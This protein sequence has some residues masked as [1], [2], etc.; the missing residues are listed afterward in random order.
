[1]ETIMTPHTKGKKYHDTILRKKF[2]IGLHQ[3]QTLLEEQDG[4]CYL[5]GNDSWRNL[6][7]D[8]CHTTGKVRR[9]LCSPCNQALGLFYDN[10][11][12]MRKAADYVEA[13]FTLP[14]DKEVI[15]KP[16]SERAR[17]RNVVTTPKGVYNSFAEAG[18]VYGVDATTIGSWCG[19]YKNSFPKE[20]FTYEKVFK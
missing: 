13:E 5:C 4:K 12:V 3:Y 1:M 17:H 6:A 14:E 19:A 2:S 20:G 8:H 7:V 16:H 18:K 9:L 11:E 15:S 10:P